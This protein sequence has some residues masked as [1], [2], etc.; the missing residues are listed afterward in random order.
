MQTHL[1]PRQLTPRAQIVDVG[2]VT[3][4]HRLTRRTEHGRDLLG[5]VMADQRWQEQAANG[6][7]AA[8]FVIDW[9]ATY[10]RCPQGQQSV[11][12]LERPDRHG[13]P[14]V[15]IAFSKP[16]CAACAR[17][18]DCTRAATAPRALRIRERD[19]YTVLQAARARPQTAT[20][21]KVYA[22]RAGIEGTMAQ[23]TRRGGLRRSRYSGLVKTRLLH[24]LVATARN[25]MRVAAWLAEIPR[26]RT[27]PS[28][29]AALAAAA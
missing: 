3:S 14:T 6:F 24:L 7:A 12:W 22:R 5:P 26:A 11:V 10:A 21:Q 1:A 15:R 28:A 27:R 13:H 16:V 23:G 19:H 25:F 4:D 9:D 17:R 8:P 2:Y 29:F 20:F 18:A